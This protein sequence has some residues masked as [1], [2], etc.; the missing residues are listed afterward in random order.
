[1]KKLNWQTDFLKLVEERKDTPFEWGV[2]DCVMFAADAV[3]VMG[4]E[5]PAKA[6]RGKYKTEAGAKR[7]LASAYGDL[8]KAWDG[9]LEKIENVNFVQNGDVVLFDGELGLTSAI[10]WMGGVF[11]PTMDGVRFADEQHHKILAAWRV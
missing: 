8:Y 1:M 11:V 3:I 2:N 4:N 7:H 9:K 6:S 10:Y 5:D